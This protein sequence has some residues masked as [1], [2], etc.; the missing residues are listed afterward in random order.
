VADDAGTSAAAASAAR[1]VT[2]GRIFTELFPTLF[3]K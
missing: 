1:A 3:G 2:G